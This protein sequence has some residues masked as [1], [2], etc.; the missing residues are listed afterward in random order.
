MAAST[1]DDGVILY[2]AVRVRR[3]MAIRSAAD[4]VIRV[5]M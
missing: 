5:T 1:S 4:D 2:V 3:R